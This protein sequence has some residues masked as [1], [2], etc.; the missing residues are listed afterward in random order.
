MHDN[1]TMTFTVTA[2][3]KTITITQPEDINIHEFLDTCRSLAIALEYHHDSWEDAILT[4]ADDIKFADDQQVIDEYEK[5]SVRVQ[6]GGNLAYNPPLVK[7]DMWLHK[8][9][10][11]RPY[12]DID[13]I[14]LPS[15]C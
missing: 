12:P 15:T 10:Q 6:M 5:E 13:N 3:N 1:D 4:M 9:G 14:I 8:D 7:Q 2:F 11:Q